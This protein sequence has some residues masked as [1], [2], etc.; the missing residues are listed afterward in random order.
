VRSSFETT[1]YYF[2]AANPKQYI[3]SYKDCVP[4]VWKQDETTSISLLFNSVRGKR[5]EKGTFS[6][7]GSSGS[8]NLRRWWVV[9]QILALQIQTIPF[10]VA[11]QFK[12]SWRHSVSCPSVKAVYKIIVTGASMKR[13]DAYRSAWPYCVGMEIAVQHLLQGCR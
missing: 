2:S 11:E 5:R 3:F 8:R 10:T 9:L 13:Y 4:H 7:G 1:C 12:K 6:P